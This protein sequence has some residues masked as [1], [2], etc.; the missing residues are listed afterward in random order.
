MYEFPYLL[1]E[2]NT[3]YEPTTSLVIWHVTVIIQYCGFHNV[4]CICAYSLKH[5]IYKSYLSYGQLPR[6]ERFILWRTLKFQRCSLCHIPCTF[7]L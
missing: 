1:Q 7:Y 6:L 5:Y 2:Y 3:V 4:Q